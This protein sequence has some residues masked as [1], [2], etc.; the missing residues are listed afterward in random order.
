MTASALA[1]A[2]LGALERGDIPGIL[3]LFRPGAVVHSPLYGSLPAAEFYPRLLEDTSRSRL[4]LRGVTR[5]ER[6]VGIWFR[7]DWT[8][9]SGA[10][11]G[12][13]CVDLLELDEQGL[14]EALRIFYDTAA[15]R[16]AFERETGGS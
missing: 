4:E 12:F 7:F 15:T 6:L 9:A 16:P 8:L 10:P 3:A 11:A 5:G 13:E 1:S 14:I 2:Y